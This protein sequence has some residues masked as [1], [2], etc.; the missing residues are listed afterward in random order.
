MKAPFHNSRLVHDDELVVGRDGGHP[1]TGSTRLLAKVR[2]LPR[3]LDRR[4]RRVARIPLPLDGR[5]LVPVL[6]VGALRSHFELRGV[7]VIL[8][9]GD[10]FQAPLYPSAVLP[11]EIARDRVPRDLHKV[12]VVLLLGAVE[13]G[14]TGF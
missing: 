8:S 14:S 1:G 11:S 13:G 4:H 12:P 5:K 10:R 9:L 2:L 3:S 6:E 7:P